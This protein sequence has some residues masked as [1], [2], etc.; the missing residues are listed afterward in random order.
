MLD[1]DEYM[2]NLLAAFVHLRV[3]AFDFPENCLITDGHPFIMKTFDRVPHLEYITVS[4]PVLC[5]KR[6]GGELVICDQAE[7]PLFIF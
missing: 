2:I 3:F 5:Y 7:C 1:V 4:P 6:V